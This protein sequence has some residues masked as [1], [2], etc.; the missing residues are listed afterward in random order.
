MFS[1][2]TLIKHVQHPP[3]PN[4]SIKIIWKSIYQFYLINFSLCSLGDWRWDLKNIPVYNKKVV[5]AVLVGEVVAS[6]SHGDNKNI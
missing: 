5:S 1:L 4:S 2:P 6:W 3:F